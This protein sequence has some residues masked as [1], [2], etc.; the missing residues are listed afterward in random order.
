MGLSFEVD[1]WC[2]FAVISKKQWSIEAGKCG[3]KIYDDF[4]VSFEKRMGMSVHVTGSTFPNGNRKSSILHLGIKR[5]AFSYCFPTFLVAEAPTSKSHPSP[6]RIV[7]L[8]CTSPERSQ[9][10]PAMD[11]QSNCWSLCL[12]SVGKVFV[13]FSRWLLTFSIM[14]KSLNS[15]LNPLSLIGPSVIDSLSLKSFP[16]SHAKLMAQMETPTSTATAMLV[17]FDKIV[18]TLKQLTGISRM[19]VRDVTEVL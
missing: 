5:S 1:W 19:A 9:E 17:C 13:R 4:H 10:K 15:T 7:N 12:K 18:T 11:G 3:R 14:F 16:A 2:W 8:D 6:S